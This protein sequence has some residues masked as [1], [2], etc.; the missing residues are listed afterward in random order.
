MSLKGTEAQTVDFD[1]PKLPAGMYSA[2]LALSAN[3]AVS[4]THLDVYKR[5]VFGY[6]PFNIPLLEFSDEAVTRCRSQ[7]GDRMAC[8]LYTSRCV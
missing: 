8:L 1:F 2:E 3:G 5:Q 7:G 6:L 4:Y